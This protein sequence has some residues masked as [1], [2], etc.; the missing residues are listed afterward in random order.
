M[1][2]SR[3]LRRRRLVPILA[4]TLA[5]LLLL[6]GCGG[7]VQLRKPHVDL[8]SP[9]LVKLKAEAGIADCPATQPATAPA[10]DGLPD[11]TLPCLGGGRGVH[12][13]SLRGPMVI[14]LW[15]QSCAPCRHEMPVLQRFHAK[16]GK[17]VPVLGIDWED[18]Q[19]KLA[20][21]LAKESGVTY[22]QVVD[23]D[24]KVRTSALPTT[25]LLDKRGRIVFQE[26]MVIGRVLDLESLV[27]ENLGLDLGLS[28]TGPT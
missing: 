5:A 21:E 27:R 25:I 7:G 6:A 11:V 24:R 22:P 13:A 4:T 20:L 18:F 19:P 17:T 1:T 2:H 12:L 26:P 8:D 3:A 10:R 9:A 23:L 15:A 28:Q 16:H 14:N